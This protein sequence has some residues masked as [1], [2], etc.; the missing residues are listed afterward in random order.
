MLALGRWEKSKEVK[1]AS[2]SRVGRDIQTPRG[3]RLGTD[4]YE[5][6]RDPWS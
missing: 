6:G 4:T 2:F 3:E 5:G 1:E